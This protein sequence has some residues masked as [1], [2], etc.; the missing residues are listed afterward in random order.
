MPTPKALFFDVNETLL[1]L[2][3]LRTSLADVLGGRKDLLPLWFRMLLHY[4]LVESAGGQFRPFGEIGAATL[5]MVGKNLGIKLDSDQARAAIRPIT[6]LPPHP[7]V[8]PA[9]QRLKEGGFRMFTLTN[10]SFSG[11]KAQ[12]A[13]AGLTDF[14]EEC[15]SVEAIQT[16]KPNTLVYRW[17]ARR[18]G[19]KPEDCMMVAAHG[20][21][22]AGATWAG[23]RSAFIQRP[24]QQ[25]YPLADK[26]DLICRDLMAFADEMS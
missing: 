19:L 1:D 22:V 17:A 20:W 4:S 26:P 6:Q 10:S 5:Q 24:G 14:F 9:L 15:L 11:V 16:Y 18:I 8:M 13:H 21:D 3:A 25:M 7:D 2:E 12:M 23:M